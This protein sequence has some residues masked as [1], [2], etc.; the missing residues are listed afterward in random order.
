V[1][2]AQLSPLRATFSGRV[3]HMAAADVL[4]FV[5]PAALATIKGRD[6]HPEIRA[7]VIAH[8][9]E[10]EGNLLGYGRA[11]IQYFGAVVRK[12]YDRLAAGTPIFR[13][14]Q[15]D[16]SHGGR[17]PIGEVVGKARRMVDGHEATIAAVYIKPEYRSDRLNVCSLEANIAFIA[18]GEGKARA[19]DV[20][21]ITG[22]ALGDAEADT[23]GF[24]GAKFLAAL[25]A[26]AREKGDPMTKEEIIEAI[27]EAK[28][29]AGELFS[30]AELREDKVVSGIVESETE[31]ERGYGSRQTKKVE[32]LEQRLAEKEAEFETA[33]REAKGT[34]VRAQSRGALDTLISE[35]KLDD[36]QRKFVERYFGRFETDATEEEA[37]KVDLNK[38]LDGQLS[39]FRALAADV[40]GVGEKK[41]GEPDATGTPTGDGTGQEFG[42]G[43]NPL[44]PV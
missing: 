40:Y 1:K 27:K 37:L 12:I 5:D 34:A 43:N 29:A 7:Y 2:V 36:A 6:P 18:E 22:I 21:E 13:G 42:P 24:P 17:E 26:F 41:G 38:F 33:L 23:P 31:K 32:K 16:N 19:V 9:G 28:L 25:Q 3:E 15:A 11:A 14:H 44:I 10:A 20:E 30:E 35:R 39:E 4:E 8:E